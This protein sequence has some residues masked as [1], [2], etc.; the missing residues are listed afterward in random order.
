MYKL[1]ERGGGGGGG[2][3]GGNLGNARKKTFFFKR[4]VPLSWGLNSDDFPLFKTSLALLKAELGV[5]QSLILSSLRAVEEKM[6]SLAQV[7]AEET[8]ARA[9]LLIG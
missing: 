8:A 2:G 1:P 7:V 3:G 4:G 6:A 5:L 9:Q